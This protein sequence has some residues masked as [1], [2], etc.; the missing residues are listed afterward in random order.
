MYSGVQKIHVSQALSSVRYNQPYY[1]LLGVAQLL[2]LTLATIRKFLYK[3]FAIN[4]KIL[5]KSF[6]FSSICLKLSNTAIGNR[7]LGK[8]NR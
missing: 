1:I 2:L 7:I 5:R 3:Y 8:N 6:V 4:E